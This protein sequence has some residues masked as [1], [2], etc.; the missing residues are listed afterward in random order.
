MPTWPVVTLLGDAGQAVRISSHTGLGRG[1][2]WVAVSS[3]RAWRSARGWRSRRS[4]SCRRR[5]AVVVAEGTDGQKCPS[6]PQRLEGEAGGQAHA[7]RACRV[8]FGHREQPARQ[9]CWDQMW[10]SWHSPWLLGG[11][12]LRGARPPADLCPSSCQEAF[13]SFSCTLASQPRQMSRPVL[14]SR[15]VTVRG[16]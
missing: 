3:R 13:G 2:K 6:S 10:V 12:G 1:E 7:C 14:G 9:G 16:R 8:E 5:A 4:L 15:A 11:P